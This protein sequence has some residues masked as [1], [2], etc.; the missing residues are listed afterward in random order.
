M[1]VAFN[2]ESKKIAWKKKNNRSLSIIRPAVVFGENNRGNV[3][4]L[5]KQLANN[6]FI[7][8]GSGENKKSI[9]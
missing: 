6:R 4:N 3:F 8:V 1:L 7:M 2:N 5:M 9:A